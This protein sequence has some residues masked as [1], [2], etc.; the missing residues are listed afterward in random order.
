M[1]CTDRQTKKFESSPQTNYP[2][3]CCT[4]RLD[5]GPNNKLFLENRG[6]ILLCGMREGFSLNL[7]PFRKDYPLIA[8]GVG[9]QGQQ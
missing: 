7:A 4:G 5:S 3:H 2:D 8:I 1:I 6:F 9:R